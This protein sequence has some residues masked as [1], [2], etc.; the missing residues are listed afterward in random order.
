MNQLILQVPGQTELLRVSITPND[1]AKL[2][3]LL[4]QKRLPQVF[5]LNGVR[6]VS[7]TILGFNDNLSPE[8]NPFQD[9][10]V[11]QVQTQFED[12]I[13]RVRQSDWYQRGLQARKQHRA[14]SH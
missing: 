10:P 5:T 7:D 3:A 2:Q 14:G 6:I 11:Q 8:E 4:E 13:S 12:V 9:E 1:E